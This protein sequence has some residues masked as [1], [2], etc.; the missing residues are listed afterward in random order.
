M[1]K[2][3]KTLSKQQKKERHTPQVGLQKFKQEILKEE[4]K[5]FRSQDG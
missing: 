1:E 2:M 4:F 3:K 5:L